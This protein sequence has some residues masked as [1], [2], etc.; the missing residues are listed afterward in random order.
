[1]QY[2]SAARRAENIQRGRAVRAGDERPETATNAKGAQ[3]NIQRVFRARGRSQNRGFTLVELMIVVAIIGILAAMAVVGYSKFMRSSKTAEAKTALGMM[4]KGNIAE[5]NRENGE[6]DTLAVGSASAAF[7][8]AV[9]D[10]ASGAVPGTFAN[11]QGKKYQSKGTDWTADQAVDATH[12]HGKGFSCLKFS[13]DTPQAYQYDYDASNYNASGATF[14]ATANGDLNNDNTQSHF[15]YRGKVQDGKVTLA[16]TIEEV[17][18]DELRR[19]E[20]GAVCASEVACRLGM[21]PRS[22][23][24]EGTARGRLG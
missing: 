17:N 13:M 21:R 23:H 19:R 12:P 8:N 5:Y 2:G 10:K 24:F 9:C 7:S 20:G 3:M 18:P 22:F 15:N 14:T 6:T 4:T 11:V 1:V 16:P